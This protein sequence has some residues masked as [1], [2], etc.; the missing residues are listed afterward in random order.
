MSEYSGSVSIG[1]DTMTVQ[2]VIANSSLPAEKRALAVLMLQR[3]RDGLTEIAAG[4]YKDYTPKY[5]ADEQ[6]LLLSFEVHSIWFSRSPT[7]D[8]KPVYPSQS[9]VPPSIVDAPIEDV[10]VD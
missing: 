1:N 6:E 5:T 10:F 8:G 2:E 3:W 9:S 7:I 4:K